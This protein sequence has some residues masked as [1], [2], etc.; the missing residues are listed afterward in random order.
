MPGVIRETAYAA[1]ISRGSTPWSLTRS[2]RSEA[3]AAA[4]PMC[5]LEARTKARRAGGIIGPLAYGKEH[6]GGQIGGHP[7]TFLHT[8]GRTQS[9]VSDP[10]PFGPVPARKERR[11]YAIAED[12]SDPT[13]AARRHLYAFAGAR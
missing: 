8:H 12:L 10:P 1:S 3:A 13:L 6:G 4:A 5:K 9:V 2:L 11:N 7:G